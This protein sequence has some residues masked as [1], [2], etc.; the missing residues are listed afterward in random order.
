ME[1]STT[2]P[3]SNLGISHFVYTNEQYETFAVDGTLLTPDGI[4]ES[5][6]DTQ[7][8]SAV[9][10]LWGQKITDSYK[11]VVISNGK[12]TVRR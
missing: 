1:I 4:Q 5:I 7:E 8:P 2:S 6:A 12:K 9:Y 11:G 3:L 10:N